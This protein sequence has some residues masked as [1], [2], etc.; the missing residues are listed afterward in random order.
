MTVAIAPADE[1]CTALVALLNASTGF[2]LEIT[3]S[4]SRMEIDRLEEIH[5]LRIDVVAIDETQLAERLD[6]A[7]NTSHTIDVVIR[8]KIDNKDLEIPELSLLCRQIFNTLNN[9]NSSDHRVQIWE[10]DLDQKER[11]DKNLLN[12]ANLFLSTIHLRVEV[13]P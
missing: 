2:V 10:C 4:Y 12:D 13:Q 8:K 5:E 9:W 6:L 11:P 3:A 7:D 1:A